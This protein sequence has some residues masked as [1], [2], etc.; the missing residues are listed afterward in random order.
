KNN[1]KQI[2]ITIR[3]YHVSANR[4]PPGAVQGTELPPDR[5]LSW[6]FEIV[7]HLEGGACYHLDLQKAWDDP[8]NCPPRMSYPKSETGR[9]IVVVGPMRVFQCRPVEYDPDQPSPVHYVG[10]AGL[11]SD[12]AELPLTNPRAGI[13]GHD[14]KL[15]EDDVKDGLSTTL[16]V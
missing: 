9:R 6:Y 4:Y 1:L 14:R 2:G 12:A 13:F 11:G 8:E 15:N 7:P 5:R 16:M 10:V 3:S